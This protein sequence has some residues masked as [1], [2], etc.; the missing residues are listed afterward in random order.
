MINERVLK[1]KSFLLIKQK[2]RLCNRY[3]SLSRIHFLDYVG[4][5]IHDSNDWLNNEK[6]EKLAF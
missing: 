4:G 6:E 1:I 3:L 2:S 5:N